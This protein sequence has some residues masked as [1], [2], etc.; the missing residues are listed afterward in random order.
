[1][2]LH[3]TILSEETIK[4]DCFDYLVLG[5]GESSF[6]ELTLTILGGDIPL[7]Q[8][9]GIAYMV[10][11]EVVRNAPRELILNLDDIPH[12]ANHLIINKENMLPDDFGRIFASRGCPYSCIFCASNAIWSKAVRYRSPENVVSEIEQINNKF[13]PVYFH[14]EDDSFSLNKTYVKQICDLLLSRNIRINW[15]CE[16]RVDLVA[17]DLLKIMKKAGCA[18]ILLGAESGNESTLKKIKKNTTLAQIRKAV[19]LCKKHRMETAIFFMIGFPW[20]GESEIKQTVDFMKE[21]DP[22]F[23]VYSISTPYPGTELFEIYK[24]EGL[25]PENINWST[26]F[27]QSPDMFLTTKLPKDRVQDIIESTEKVFLGHNRKKQRLKLLNPFKLF[28][29]LKEH[30]KSPKELWARVK[31]VLN[32]KA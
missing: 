11:G 31:Y 29:E 4:N 15:G 17:D 6:L 19:S 5:E 3:P 7:T 23:A 10:N 8:I 9:R 32:V 14:F 18:K 25:I 13:H 1:G 22:Q 16:T 24:Q 26:F 27:H 2:G 21:L 20:E 30:Y 28:L 12:P